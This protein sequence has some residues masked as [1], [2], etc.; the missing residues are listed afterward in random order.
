MKL[1]R[2][3]YPLAA[4]REHSGTPQPCGNCLSNAWRLHHVQPHRHNLNCRDG[5]RTMSS[6]WGYGMKDALDAKL[7]GFTFALDSET[8]FVFSFP[9]VEPE[10]ALQSLSP[11]EQQIVR[12]LLRGASYAQVAGE[13]RTSVRTVANQVAALYKKLGISSRSELEHR[14]LTLKES[15]GSR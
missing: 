9:I 8:F 3:V 7:H 10:D 12:S 1:P 14:L 5:C 13:R 2:V 11:S 4:S 15:K 6:A